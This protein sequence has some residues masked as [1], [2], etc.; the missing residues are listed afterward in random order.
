M[1]VTLPFPPAELFPNR[2][3]GKHWTSTRMAKDSYRDH[4]FYLT[5]QAAKNWEPLLCDVALSV[6]FVQ[7][8]MRRRDVD[9][10]LAASK[11]AIDGFAKGLGM[12]DRQ[13]KPLKVDWTRK[14]GSGALV[15]E[16]HPLDVIAAIDK[17][18]G[19]EP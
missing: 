18:M 6:T 1:K 3:A 14:K 15:L 5:K 13:F 12:D 4:A 16:L 11:H 9:N 8:D 10:M 2:S 17:E 7:P 19:I